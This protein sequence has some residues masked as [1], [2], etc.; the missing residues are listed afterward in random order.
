MLLVLTIR[1]L[2]VAGSSSAASIALGAQGRAKQQSSVGVS[3]AGHYRG[4]ESYS[5]LL[6]LLCSHQTSF[7]LVCRVGS[8]LA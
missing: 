7:C 4:E 8:C 2:G 6:S 3:S 1:C 5:P